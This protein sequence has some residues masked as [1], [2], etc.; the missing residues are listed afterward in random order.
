MDE[1]EEESEDEEEGDETA[2]PDSVNAAEQT[3]E[4]D[5]ERFALFASQVRRKAEALN[6]RSSQGTTSAFSPA[7]SFS[8]STDNVPNNGIDISSPSWNAHALHN[9]IVASLH[10]AAGQQQGQA[11][12]LSTAN[13][14]GIKVGIQNIQEKE[15]AGA[16]HSRFAKQNQIDILVSGRERSVTF[17]FLRQQTDILVLFCQ[18]NCHWS[19]NPLSIART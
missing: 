14:E 19:L 3:N 5:D 4:E 16:S 8:F 1:E 18:S 9:N 13:H 11:G 17:A 2:L 12:V 10:D 15:G 6:L 7:Q